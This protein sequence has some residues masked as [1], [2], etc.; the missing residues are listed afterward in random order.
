MSDVNLGKCF[1]GAGGWPR[2]TSRKHPGSPAVLGE[3]G[4][5]LHRV[6]HTFAVCRRVRL[7]TLL[8]PARQRARRRVPFPVESTCAAPCLRSARQGNTPPRDRKSTRLN[9]SHSQISYAVFCL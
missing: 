7:L 8:L 4:R 9:S 5:L 3:W 6:A 2:L 1:D